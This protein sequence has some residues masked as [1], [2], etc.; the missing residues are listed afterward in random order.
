V[1]KTSQ[2]PRRM[3]EPLPGPF[4]PSPQGQ[5]KRGEKE[6]GGIKSFLR[7]V[8]LQGTSSYVPGSRSNNVT[9]RESQEEWGRGK[10]G[11]KQIFGEMITFQVF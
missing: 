2:L 6:K 10:D 7:I 3:R 5:R 11:A 9:R 8:K 4:G 1:K